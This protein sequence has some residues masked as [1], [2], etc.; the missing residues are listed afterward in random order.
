MKQHSTHIRDFTYDSAKRDLTV[1]F[2]N[3]HQYIHHEVPGHVY[4]S[5]GAVFSVG[6]YYHCLKRK[7]TKVTVVKPELLG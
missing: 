2:H 1:T 7:Y 4:D 3:G 6:R 5:M